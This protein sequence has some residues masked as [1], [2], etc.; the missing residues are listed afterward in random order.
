[1][2]DIIVKPIEREII[3]NGT[4]KYIPCFM[5]GINNRRIKCNMWLDIFDEVGAIG[6]IPWQ[7]KKPIGQM[8]FMPKKYARKITIPFSNTKVNFDKTL[9]IGCLMICG[10]Q[11]GSGHWNKGAASA[12]I[13]ELIGFSR[14]KGYRRIE[15]CVD[16][17]PPQ[18]AGWMTSF[19]PFKKFG[20]EI[21]PES[22]GWENKENMKMC[23]LNLD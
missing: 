12:L 20:F 10:D 22:F 15:A 3:L 7:D 8:F 6:F 16:L 17:R 11:I 5:F 21:E 23:A 18:E 1:M 4:G 13:Q 2:S 19:Y 14:T 9:V